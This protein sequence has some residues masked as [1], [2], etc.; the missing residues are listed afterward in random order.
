MRLE[1]DRAVEQARRAT[2]LRSPTLV[3]D[4][5]ALRRDIRAIVERE[6]GT[7]LIG[8][9]LFGSR[10]RGDARE[11]S[12]WDVAVLVDQKADARGIT[13]RLL[14]A[15]TRTWGDGRT[16]VQPVVLRPSDL[17]ARPSLAM[18]LHADAVPL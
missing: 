18:N 3:D 16:Q 8:V 2:A 11:D 7:D 17:E 13:Q 10:A 9:L 4:D 6:V 5:R 14:R 1:R 15:I 12:D